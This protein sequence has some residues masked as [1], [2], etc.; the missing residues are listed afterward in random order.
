M[1]PVQGYHIG[2]LAHLNRTGLNLDSPHLT[3]YVVDCSSPSQAKYILRLWLFCCLFSNLLRL[4][5]SLSVAQAIA[6]PPPSILPNLST[7][8]SSLLPSQ[9]FCFL[10]LGNTHRF[11]CSIPSHSGGP[12]TVLILVR[13]DTY[14]I[15]YRTWHLS[16]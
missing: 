9:L 8:S 14:P 2:I 7:A 1:P 10:H 4:S 11:D 16:T 3:S 12:K 6:N 5:Y 13:T 15:P